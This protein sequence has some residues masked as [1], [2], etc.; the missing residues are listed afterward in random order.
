MRFEN[1]YFSVL[2]QKKHWEI[3]YVDYTAH[4][5]V[6]ILV[7]EWISN[8]S[9]WI[10]WRNRQQRGLKKLNRPFPSGP[11]ERSPTDIDEL[12]KEMSE[13]RTVDDYCFTV[14]TIIIINCFMVSSSKQKWKKEYPDHQNLLPLEYGE[15]VT[16]E[17]E[18]IVGYYYVSS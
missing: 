3:N 9:L 1:C 16:H 2:S 15:S 13:H 6:V 18:A 8:V 11:E 4:C 10:V 5:C 14:T 12:E 7:F 17:K